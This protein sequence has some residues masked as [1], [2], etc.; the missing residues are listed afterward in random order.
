MVKKLLLVEDDA[1]LAKF[2]IAYLKSHQYSVEWASNH[3]QTNEVLQHHSIDLIILDVMLPG[4]SGFDICV[5]VKC[6][7]VDAKMI[8]LC[9]R[10]IQKCS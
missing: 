2:M 3:Q 6:E 10:K 9:Q 4:K 5:I 7:M 8:L 1:K